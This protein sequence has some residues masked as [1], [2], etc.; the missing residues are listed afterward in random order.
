MQAFVAA[1]MNIHDLLGQSTPEW[2]RAHQSA[3]SMQISIK[4]GRLFLKLVEETLRG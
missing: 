3:Y 4:D 1:F 2:L